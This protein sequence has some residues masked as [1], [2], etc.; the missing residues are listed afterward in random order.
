MKKAAIYLA[1]AL[2]TFSGTAFGQN[3]ATQQLDLAIQTAENIQ[4]D[5]IN[6]QNAVNALVIELTVT[7][8]PETTSFSNAMWAQV[9]HVQD[10]AD[11]I[12][13]FA[14][15]A[16]QSSPVQLNTSAV[17][18]LTTQLVNQNDELIQL[19][20]QIIEAINTHHNA[21]AIALIPALREVLNTQSALAGN[22][23]TVLEGLKSTASIYQVEIHL[24]DN[25]GNPVYYNDTHGFYCHNEVT[26]VYSYPDDQDGDT[27]FLPAGTYTF[28][29][30]D[31]YFSG[32]GST[33]V[34]LSPELVNED[35]IVI[36]NL[37]YWAE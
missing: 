18:T 25:Q 10:N 32:T 37:Q 27:F 21:D 36:V 2:F 35:G 1:T 19:Q 5:V 22:L 20:A 7:N 26:G 3:N 8:N 13:Y 14:Y 17:G 9:N 31:G 6:T 23:I 15:L 29:S 33:T 16:A 28:D 24:V 34:T 30:Y 4:Q 11:N 12:D